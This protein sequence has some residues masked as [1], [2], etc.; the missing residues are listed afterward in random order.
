MKIE[1]IIAVAFALGLTAGI[2][3]GPLSFLMVSETIAKGRR[4]GFQVAFSPLLTDIPI[5]ILS[6]ILLTYL[7]NFHKIIG[8][9]SI[10]GSMFVFYLAYESLFKLRYKSTA[11]PARTGINK[12]RSLYK[13]MTA[14]FLNP[15]PYLFWLM[16]GIPYLSKAWNIGIWAIAVFI[17]IFYSCLIGSKIF[18]VLIVAK[19]RNF[20]EGKVY[21]ILMMVLGATLA[22]FAVIL[23]KEGI[24]TLNHLP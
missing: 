17:L 21:R 1:E 22:V 4:C 9:I 5:I 18:L 12:Y 13:G 19:T 3:P 2:S 23:L 24:S 8:L 15:H 14:N 11:I 7:Q 20:L 16:V 10:A 6:F